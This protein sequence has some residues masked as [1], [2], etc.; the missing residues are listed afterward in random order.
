MV[1]S[2]NQEQYLLNTKSPE[3]SHVSRN[4]LEGQTEKGKALGRYILQQQDAPVIWSARWQA[5]AKANEVVRA[6][7][8]K[9]ESLG[10]PSY[11]KFPENWTFSASRGPL[12][13][14]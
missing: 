4:W 10:K 7:Q 14:P 12:R 3:Y 11:T 9:S 8:K 5:N 2:V 6:M 1:L 13:K